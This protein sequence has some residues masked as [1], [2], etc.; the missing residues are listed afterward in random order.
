MD[1]TLVLL[2]GTNV[3]NRLENLE[4]ASLELMAAV[5]DIVQ[6][7][8]IY[9]TAPWGF[10]EQGSFLNQAILLTTELRPLRVMEHIWEIEKNMGRTK[11]VYWGPRIIDIDI[12]FYDDLVYEADNLKIPHPFM[13]ERR[14]VLEPIAEIAPEIIHPLL[15]KTVAELLLNCAD[16]TEVYKYGG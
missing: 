8:S 6:E 2:L 11:P 3:G 1:Q 15:G 13:H 12:I 5:G 4:R 14:F 7:S 10:T 9:E 16:Q